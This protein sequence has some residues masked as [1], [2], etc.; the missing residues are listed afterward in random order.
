[1]NYLS[2]KDGT[3]VVGAAPGVALI[4][5]NWSYQEKDDTNRSRASGARGTSRVY[6]GTDWEVNIEAV[7]QAGAAPL[8][9]SEYRGAHVA[10]ALA[11]DGDNIITVS[12]AG[13]VTEREYGSPIDKDVTIKLKIE[14]DSAAAAD[15]PTVTVGTGA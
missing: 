13:I 12:G 6:L 9:I 2:G 5:T 3:A 8:D 7:V 14:C 1:M 15:L 4:V 11:T 10:F